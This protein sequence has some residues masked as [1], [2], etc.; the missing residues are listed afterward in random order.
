M[1]EEFTL[2]LFIQW[3]R[4]KIY[5]FDKNLENYLMNFLCYLL[6]IHLNTTFLEIKFYALLYQSITILLSDTKQKL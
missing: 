5:I 1:D 6:M 4:L 3:K 2:I